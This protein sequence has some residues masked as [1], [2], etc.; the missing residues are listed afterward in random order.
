M[1]PA[2]A[3]KRL[4]TGYRKGRVKLVSARYGNPSKH[5]RVI[6]VTGTNGKTTTACYINEILKEAKFK[7]A[8]FTTALIEV[9]GEA[10]INDLNATVA[11]TARMQQ[12]FRDAK[13]AGVDYVV[14]E[15]RDT[16][17]GSCTGGNARKPAESATSNG[18]EGEPKF[19]YADDEDL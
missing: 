19:S 18:A 4:E 12:F 8:M 17:E 7:T 3:L 11:T 16:G 1:L 2:G 13:K 9:A 5:L 6:A 10:Q 15:V 14:L